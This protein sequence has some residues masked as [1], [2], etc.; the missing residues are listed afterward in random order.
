MLVPC[1]EG[2]RG[3]GPA[4]WLSEGNVS[5]GV[6]GPG[7][8]IHTGG[9]QPSYTLTPRVDISTSSE[10]RAQSSELRDKSLTWISLL[11]YSV[12]W[13]GL[14]DPGELSHHHPAPTGAAA[15]SKGMFR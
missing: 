5:W 8:A 13:L 14:D 15:G 2:E 4:V 6:A 12:L 11:E 9:Q 1:M 3:P 10:L 7:P